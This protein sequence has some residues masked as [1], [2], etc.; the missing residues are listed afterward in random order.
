MTSLFRIFNADAIFK[1]KCEICGEEIT[2]GYSESDRNIKKNK[3][4]KLCFEHIPKRPNFSEFEKR[5]TEKPNE[6]TARKRPKRNS[7]M[8][9]PF[10]E[11]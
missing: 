9:L 5:G 3:I 1:S 6:S 8:Q 4:K 11:V 10:G 2:Y 7:E